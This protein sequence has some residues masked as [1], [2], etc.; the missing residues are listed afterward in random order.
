MVS[1]ASRPFTILEEILFF[2][3]FACVVMFVTQ[4]L[5]NDHYNRKT[6]ERLKRLEK[7]SGIDE[8]GRVR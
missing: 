8:I 3:A 5:I 4:G 7:I 6:D 1:E 2:I